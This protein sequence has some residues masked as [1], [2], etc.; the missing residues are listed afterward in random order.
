MELVE[1]GEL[2][3][4]LHHSLVDA[5]AGLGSVALLAGEAGIGKTSLVQAFSFRHEGSSQVFWGAC[6]AL[7]AAGHPVGPA[8][9]HRVT[10]A[11][12]AHSRGGSGHPLP[13]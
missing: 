7:P 11:R 4:A 1:H 5:A 6:D 9:L 3:A 2:L 12:T 10:G 8:Q 13:S